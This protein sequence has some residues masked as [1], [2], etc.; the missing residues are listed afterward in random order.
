MSFLFLTW[1]LCASLSTSA[2]EAFLVVFVVDSSGFPTIMSPRNKDGFVFS[3]PICVSFIS[4]SCLTSVARIASTTL[5]RSGEKDKPWFV[6]HLC[7]K[8]LSRKLAIGFFCSLPQVEEVPL[9][10]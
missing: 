4:F 1:V 5:K 8:A 2:L 10:Y 9:N 7:E 3:F 6:P